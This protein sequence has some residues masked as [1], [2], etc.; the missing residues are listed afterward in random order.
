MTPRARVW[1]LVAAAAVLLVA[2]GALLFQAA[3][4]RSGLTVART[5][6]IALDRR[7]R[8]LEQQLTEQRAATAAVIQ[9]LERVGEP[10]PVVAPSSTQPIA[11]VLRPQTRNIGSVPAL[12]VPT[13]TDRLALA[14][15]LES[16]E[17]PRYRIAL[18][19]P[20][21]DHTLWTSELITATSLGQVPMVVVV[22]P[23]R[24]LKSQHYSLVL[25]GGNTSDSDVISSYT[26]E[27]LRR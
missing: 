11:L 22:I 8:A 3:R 25:T 16:H 20:A 4:L 7:T 14:L 17:F 27:V 5:E 23:A 26:F 21:S 9:E 10:A 15:Q 18:K 24:L 12:A 2:S 6:G 13:G 1:Q 19:D